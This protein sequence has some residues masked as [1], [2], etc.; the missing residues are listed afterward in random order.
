MRLLTYTNP[1]TATLNSILRLATFPYR[2][3][4]ITSGGSF[5]CF[6]ILTEF[7]IF[8][9][10]TTGVFSGIFHALPSMNHKHMITGM[11]L[12]VNDRAVNAQNDV[13]FLY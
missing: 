8:Y 13:G 10:K 5:Y 2:P 12:I 1:I 9:F 6:H 7:R 4:S 11:V 3:P